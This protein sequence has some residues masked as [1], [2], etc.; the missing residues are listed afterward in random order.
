MKYIKNAS[1]ALVL[2]SFTACDVVPDYAQPL[3]A[4]QWS[5]V[6]ERYQDAVVITPIVETMIEQANPLIDE[7]G[8]PVSSNQTVIDGIEGVLADFEYYKNSRK[9]YTFC[10]QDKIDA[11]EE[12]TEAD[13]EFLSR[14]NTIDNY[15]NDAILLN[16]DLGDWSV[17]L[18][19]HEVSHRT[20]RHSDS[21]YEMIDNNECFWC[22]TSENAKWMLRDG[23][24]SMLQTFFF[25][26][27]EN[28]LD[29]LNWGRF[30]SE[31]YQA[32]EG[33]PQALI[34]GWPTYQEEMDQGML[35][36]YDYWRAEIVDNIWRNNS[37]IDGFMNELGLTKSEIEKAF[38]NE[39][40][41]KYIQVENGKE[42][43]RCK[44]L[45]IEAKN[46][47]SVEQKA[48]FGRRA[49]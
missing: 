33:D 32:L 39:A 44:Q 4:D 43:E 8:E 20:I 5:R 26:L 25:T 49:R 30:F 7:Y 2:A 31:R 41:F 45:Y 38:S 17:D 28:A 37:E 14:H 35:Y 11:S 12:Y 40:V 23:E 16:R 18:I 36:G 47:L 22:Y 10:E 29:D 1:G 15:A 9:F 13:G 3:T 48:E 27:A 46:E 19:M 6:E 42:Y 21:Y 24:W 34:D